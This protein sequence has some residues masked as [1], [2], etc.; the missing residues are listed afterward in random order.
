[1][2]QQQQLEMLVDLLAADGIDA[3]WH[4]EDEESEVQA[5][6]EISQ[7]LAGS[8]M[9]LVDLLKASGID[10]VYIVPEEDGIDAHWEISLPDRP[11]AASAEE[12][13]EL[14]RELKRVQIDRDQWKKKAR[15]RR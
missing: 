12:V 5:H 9:E 11:E 14:K 7:E 4:E 15:A 13:L 2:S 3:T 8:L 10:A 1:M 6:W